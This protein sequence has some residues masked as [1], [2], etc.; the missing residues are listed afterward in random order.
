MYKSEYKIPH[1]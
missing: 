1:P